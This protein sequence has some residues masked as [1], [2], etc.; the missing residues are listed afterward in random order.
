MNTIE[1]LGSNCDIY[2]HLVDVHDVDLVE[3]E[4]VGQLVERLECIATNY[5]DS[6]LA[7]IIGFISVI[8]KLTE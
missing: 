2:D 5:N 1:L 7:M 3:C 6:E 8:V 4:D